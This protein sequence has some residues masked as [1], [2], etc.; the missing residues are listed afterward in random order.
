[1]K[2]DQDL[3]EDQ[4]QI[5]LLLTAT[6]YSIYLTSIHLFSSLDYLHCSY[7]FFSFE[8]NNYEMFIIINKPVITQIFMV[9]FCLKYN[10]PAS[11][12]LLI[13]AAA[14]LPLRQL[15]YL[16]IC[17]INQLK[18]HYILLQLQ[19][20]LP[21]LISFPP[22]SP[23]HTATLTIASIHQLSRYTNP[24]TVSCHQSNC[25]LPAV[26]FFLEPPL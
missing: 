10:T 14:T 3:L 9:F 1:M 17:P 5:N 20:L 19:L 21:N 15:N 26:L 23:P 6:T 8:Y 2:D 7:H 13:I 4:I 22:Y 12:E 24:S 11:A 18:L 16:Y 25:Q